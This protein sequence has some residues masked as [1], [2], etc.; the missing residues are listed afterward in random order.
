[1]AGTQDGY[2]QGYSQGV[3]A[4]ADSGDLHYCDLHDRLY[5]AGLLVPA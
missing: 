5:G 3:V 2:E 4:V 1:M